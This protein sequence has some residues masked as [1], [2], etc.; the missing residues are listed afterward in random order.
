LIYRV[1]EWG[2]RKNEGLMW[3][4]HSILWDGNHGKWHKWVFDGSVGKPHE[5]ETLFFDF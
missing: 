5:F 2:D 3:P 1:E 4:A